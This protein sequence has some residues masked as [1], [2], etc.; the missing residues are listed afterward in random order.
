LCLFFD[1]KK[2]CLQNA[3]DSVMKQNPSWTIQ[4]NKKERPISNLEAEVRF[5]MV[6]CFLHSNEQR[7]K[8]KNKKQ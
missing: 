5:S 3:L 8:K 4:H 2:K 7:K 6:R 1:N